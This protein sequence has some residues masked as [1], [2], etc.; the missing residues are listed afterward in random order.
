MKMSFRWYGKDNDSVSLAQI[1]QI[2][3]VEEI[4]WA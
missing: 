2:P 4:V 1:R 3:G